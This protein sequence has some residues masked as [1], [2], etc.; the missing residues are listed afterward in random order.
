MKWVLSGFVNGSW[1]SEVQWEEKTIINNVAVSSQ[2][3][4]EQLIQLEA[5]LA[6][7]FTAADHWLICQSG[8]QWIYYRRVCVC[9]CV[10]VCVSVRASAVRSW[11]KSIKTLSLQKL[12]F[13]IKTQTKSIR[14]WWNLLIKRHREA[15][16]LLRSFFHTVFLDFLQFPKKFLC[17]D[18]Y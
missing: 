8:H 10:C 16:G 5:R 12:V 18:C 7:T 2:G 1:W 6:A 15:L 13:C 11:E 14:Y 3:R 4:P 9:V 17:F